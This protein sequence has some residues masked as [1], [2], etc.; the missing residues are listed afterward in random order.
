MQFFGDGDEI[1]QVAKLWLTIHM[2]RISIPENGI[3]DVR[4]LAGQDGRMLHDQVPGL[5]LQ[6]SSMTS[7][8]EALA[9]KTLNEQWI[10][11]LFELEAEDH[12]VL[13]DP[14]A[15]VV[16]PGGDVLIVREAGGEIIGCVALVPGRDDTVELSKMAV[17]P[18]ARGRGVGRTL[19]LAAIE[20]ARQIGAVTV[21]LGSST[22][23]ANAVHL[24]ESVGFAHVPAEQIPLGPYARADVFMELRL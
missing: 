21:F 20:Q 6:I 24:Y 9:F 17:A 5:S 7:D 10:Q 4:M 18:S 3:L 12:R 11:G 16:G 8:V 1:A 2:V 13:G 23:L 14:F 19:L 22:K 15:E